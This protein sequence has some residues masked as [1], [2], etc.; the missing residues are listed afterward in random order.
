MSARAE[1]YAAAFYAVAKPKTQSAAVED[2]LHAVARTL[3]S[4]DELRT[5]LTDQAIPAETPAGNRRRPPRFARSSRSRRRWSAL[6]WELAGRVNLPGDHRRLH[7]E[8]GGL[9]RRGS[10]RGALCRLRSTT[11]R[12]LVSRK[13]WAGRP[14]R[15]SASRSRS[16]RACSAASSPKSATRSST[17]A[18]VAVS[19][20]SRKA[21][22]SRVSVVQHRI[23][24]H[25]RRAP[26]APRGLHADDGVGPG[27]PRRR[28]RRRYRPRR[29]SAQR[30][31]QRTARVRRWR[32][33]HRPEP[34]R[35]VDRRRAPRRPATTSRK[36]R[37]S[38][39][40]A[41]SS[42]SRWATA[43]SVASW[44]RSVSPLDG[45][46]PIPQDIIRRVEIQAPG[47]VDRQPVKEPLQTGIKVIDAMTP[48][49]RGQRELII[50]DRKTGKTS[51]AVDTII[52]QKGL[53]VKCIYVGIGQKASTVA[54]LVATLEA[55]GA[56]EYTVVVNAAASD[57]P[58]FKYLAPVLGLRHGPAL[59][60][61]QAKPRS[62]STTTCPSRPRP[63]APCRCCCAAR[64]AARRTPATSST[65]TA[66]CSS[67]PRALSKELGSGSLTALPIIETKAGDI[68]AYIPTNV[69][70]ITDGQIFLDLDLFNSGVRPA[71]NVGTSV[72]RVGGSAQIKAMKCVAGGLK[73]DLANFR[74][75]EA[76][77]GFGAELDKASQNL[78]DRGRRLVELLKQTN[79]QPLSVQDQVVSIYRRHQRLPRRARRRRRAS[80]RDRTARRRARPS[81][82]RSSTPSRTA[83]FPEDELKAAVAD[84]AGRFVPSV[85]S[86]GVRTRWQAARSASFGG[87]SRAWSLRRRSRAPWSSSL[88]AVST[89]R[90]SASPRPA[91][92]AS[93]SPR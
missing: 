9:P 47:V 22:S 1:G 6:W 38:R 51:V 62:S 7:R 81:T 14:A 42:R 34:R 82:V 70:S 78:I 63:T 54:E 48:I 93:R 52:N 43:C 29:R 15:R 33:G 56:M 53:G 88:P 59:D 69:I 23:R 12:R 64:R 83:T 19:I 91:P 20:N 71:M 80:L 84:F 44:T 66:V 25:R 76:F 55:A 37:P 50:G 67:A 13:R 77:A 65:C 90:S 57:P 10:G 26:Q 60:G 5:T 30:G 40:P 68:S 18:F 72:S 61:E 17:A 36:A 86:S 16:T 4:N 89:R 49:G 28:G 3:E 73:L 41:A 74:E 35:R 58:P 45:K 11:T 2:E 79:G 27:R 85:T 39:P 87:A 92:T 8:G 31:G 32:A 46:G 21:C 75:L 24:R